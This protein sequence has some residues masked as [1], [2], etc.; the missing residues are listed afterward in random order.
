MLVVMLFWNTSPLLALQLLWINLITDSMPAIALGREAIDPGVM[1]RNPKLKDESLFAHGLS[2]RIFLQGLMFGLLSVFAFWLGYAE[3]G[4]VEGGRTMAFFV[5]ALSQVV[6]AFNMRSERSLFAI[7]M[8]SNKYMNIAALVSTLLLC[9]V[10]FIPP[11]AAVFG[12]VGLPAFM[13]IIAVALSFVSVAVLEFSK[14]FGLIKH[15]H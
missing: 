8:F 13:Y 3:T 2:L 15:Q 4:H 10:V 9:A 11:V 14:K 6:H 7:G 5:L 1:D 12:M